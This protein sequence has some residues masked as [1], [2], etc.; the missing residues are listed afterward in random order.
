MS[1]ANAVI[2]AAV[3]YARAELVTLAMRE[4]APVFLDRRRVVLIDE[5]LPG[6]PYH[7][8]ALELDIADGDRAW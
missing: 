5:G 3:H 6:A 2:G 7:H 8:E 1:V 4:G